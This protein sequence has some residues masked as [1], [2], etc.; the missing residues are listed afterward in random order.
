MKNYFYTNQIALSTS[1][2]SKILQ[3]INYYDNFRFD[4]NIIADIQKI[5]DLTKQNS[6]SRIAPRL[7]ELTNAISE[8]QKSQINSI[9]TISSKFNLIFG[10]Q[11]NFTKNLEIISKQLGST[12]EAL[13][14]LNKINSFYFY[15]DVQTE[16]S[17]IEFN[18]EL[19]DEEI[20]NTFNNNKEL[21]EEIKIVISES[22]V[23]KN[24]D[25]IELIY[26]FLI[27]KIPFIDRKKYGFII[28]LFQFFIMSY[29]LY[30]NY[31]TNDSIDN[32]IIPSLEE[33]TE[34]NNEDYKN[35]EESIEENNQ[36]TNDKLDDIEKSVSDKIDRLI[37]EMRKQK[38]KE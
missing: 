8:N 17:N 33:Q 16:F 14:N 27:S 4:K 13:K 34:R 37:E 1:N 5:S 6:F 30:S 31:S 10:T 24:S 20:E 21:I 35:I 11:S 23:S 7:I 36:K 22:N 29:G 19:T 2:I 32:I 9:N 18:T 12:S 26:N 28:L 3:N 38:D 15:K 25:T